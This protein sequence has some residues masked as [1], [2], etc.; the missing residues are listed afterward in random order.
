MG[1]HLLTDAQVEAFRRDGFVVVP[2]F[3]DLEQD[4]RPIQR[5]IH[6]IVG[7]VRRKH[8]LPERSAPY[9]PERFDDGYQELIARDRAWGGEVYDAV[10]QIPAFVRLV[11]SPR[12]EAVFRQLRGTELP[13]VAAGGYGIRIDNPHE[14]RYRGDWHQEF[15]AQLRSEDGVTYWTTLVELTAD[16]G[17]VRFCKGS[18]AAGY[19]RVHTKDPANPDKTG[20]YGLTLERRDEVVAR[21]PQVA[22]LTRPGDLVILDFKVIHSSGFNVGSRSRWT[23]QIRYFNFEDP[24]GIRLSWCGAF[25][26]GK[27]FARIRPDLV[28]P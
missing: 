4:I 9:S 22:P 26:A 6:R 13:G 28:V 20:A 27:D 21:Y 19:L 12:H 8:G 24:E 16:M 11:G 7:L 3:Y 17:P 5:D 1:D 14:D 25:A 23:A 2:G 10:K 18:H 15:H